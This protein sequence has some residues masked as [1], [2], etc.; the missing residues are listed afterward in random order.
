ME[1]SN[2]MIYANHPLLWLICSIGIIIVL[3]QS[4]L[5]IK[6]S[7]QAGKDMEI[8]KERMNKGIKTAAIA[9]IGPAWK[10]FSPSCHNGISCFSS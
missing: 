9:S 10:S 3:I 6:K 1:N 2:H 4:A 7:I 5:I 8:P